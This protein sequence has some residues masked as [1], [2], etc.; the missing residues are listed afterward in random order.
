M[1]DLDNDIGRMVWGL[2][3]NAEDLFKIWMFQS[4]RRTEFGEKVIRD[5][6][7]TVIGLNAVLM[8]HDANRRLKVVSNG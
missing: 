4:S 1:P 3:D 6:R 7:E 5:I 2:R 8:S